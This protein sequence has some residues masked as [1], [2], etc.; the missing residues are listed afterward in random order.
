[1]SSWP[2]KVRPDSKLKFLHRS[3]SA[4]VLWNSKGRCFTCMIDIHIIMI[5]FF[6]LKIQNNWASWWSRSLWWSWSDVIWR[7]GGQEW[8]GS[9]HGAR[10]NTLRSPSFVSRVTRSSSLSPSSHCSD[11]IIFIIYILYYINISY[12]LEK[13]QWALED[14]LITFKI[15]YLIAR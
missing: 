7:P 11:I 6:H 1:M 2:L 14:D 15:N 13:E 3:S 9:G 4:E 10:W 12:L 5:S 8:G